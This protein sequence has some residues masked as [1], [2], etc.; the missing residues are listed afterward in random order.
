MDVN[1]KN[2]AELIVE[3]NEAKAKITALRSSEAKFLGLFESAPDAIIILDHKGRISLVN[4]QVEKM[5]GYSRDE[6]LGQSI[7]ILVP[8]RFRDRHLGHRNAYY[9]SPHT[10]PMGI[11]LDLYVLCKDGRE[12]PVE[13][14][15]SPLKLD[16][17]LYITS[18]VRDI[19]E[20]KKYEEYIK[21]INKELERRVIERTEELARSN[22]DLEQFAYVASHDLQEPL[23]MVASYTQLL[24]KRYKNKLDADADE[25]IGYAVDGANRMQRLINDLLAYSRVN[26][27]G[28]EFQPTNCEEVLARTLIN[29]RLTIEESEAEI[30]HDPLPIVSADVLQLGQVFQNLIANAIKFHGDARP[31]IHIS[32]QRSENSWLFIFRDNGIG[33]D[34][35]YFERIFVIF[36]RLHGPQDYTGSGIGLAICKKIIERHGGHI[37]VESK[38]GNGSAFHFTIPIKE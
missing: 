13:I 26:T 19:T 12:L 37:W 16:D 22:A 15:L 4:S 36:Q 21:N 23:R 35:Q 28:K 33:I 7:E 2:I 18:I 29:L 38:P 6:L 11:G 5:F 1:E 27:R 31:H 24:A 25:F 14:S 9:A 3:L 34:P 10:R 30:T 32:A 20:R 17:G 8:E